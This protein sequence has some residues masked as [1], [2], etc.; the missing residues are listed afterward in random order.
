MTVAQNYFEKLV[1]EGIVELKGDVKALRR[2]VEG[3][4]GVLTRMARLEE[5]TSLKA[6]VLTALAG[7]IPGLVA[8]V[9]TLLLRGGSR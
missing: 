9:L 4:N 2:T 6:L 7:A 3:E 1:L 8:I 5:R